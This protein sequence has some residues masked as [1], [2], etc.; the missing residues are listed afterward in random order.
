ML[1]KRLKMKNG[2]IAFLTERSA[3]TG[4]CRLNWLLLSR[5]FCKHHTL[6]KSVLGRTIPAANHSGP[7]C[8]NLEGKS[9]S[10]FAFVNMIGSFWAELICGSRCTLWGEPPREP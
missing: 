6:E 5:E 9:P 4:V 1:N 2:I 3:F 10:C 7:R 8:C